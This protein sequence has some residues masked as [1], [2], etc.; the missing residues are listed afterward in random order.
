VLEVEPG[1]EYDLDV[2]LDPEVPY[3]EIV[4]DGEVLLSGF[5][6]SFDTVEGARLGVQPEAARGATQFG[7]TIR[8]VSRTPLCDRLVDRGE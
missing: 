4:H 8:A 1:A 2:R 5:P 6:M 3:I 7:G